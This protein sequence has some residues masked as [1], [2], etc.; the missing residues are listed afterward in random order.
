MLRSSTWLLPWVQ[1]LLPRR[2]VES[3]LTRGVDNL[4][5]PLLLQE[6]HH[7]IKRTQ[8]LVVVLLQVIGVLLEGPEELHLV[9]LVQPT[10]I[11]LLL[12]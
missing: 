8:A 7:N 2:Q 11:T 10:L 9:L 5:Q 6:L 4:V 1:Q 3:C 12:V